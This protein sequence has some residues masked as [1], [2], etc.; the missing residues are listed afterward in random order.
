MPIKAKLI[1]EGLAADVSALETSEKTKPSIEYVCSLTNEDHLEFKK[2]TDRYAEYGVIHNEE[3][4][5]HLEDGIYELKIRGHRVL[6]FHDKNTSKKHLIC[7]HGFKKQRNKTP[8]GQIKKAKKY[9]SDYFKG[10]G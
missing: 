5:K 4:F 7:T 10:K 3:Q 9:R 8:K 2:R 6:C 1:V